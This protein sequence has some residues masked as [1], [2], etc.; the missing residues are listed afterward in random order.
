LFPDVG[1]CF[2]NFKGLVIDFPEP[3]VPSTVE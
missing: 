3:P 2:F 1:G